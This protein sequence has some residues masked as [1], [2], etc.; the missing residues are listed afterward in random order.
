MVFSKSSELP[1]VWTAGPSGLEEKELPELVA[2][3]LQAREAA[4]KSQV[5]ADTCIRLRRA[6]RAN[7]RPTGDRKAIGSWVYMKRMSDKQWLG[8]GQV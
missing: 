5:Q 2:R 6:L 3:H 1:G 4:R 8:P 7:I